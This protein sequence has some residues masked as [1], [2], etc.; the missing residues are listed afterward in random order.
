MSDA[1]P[2]VGLRN[3]SGLRT[4]FRVLGPVVVGVGL[5]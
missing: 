4:L 3:Q 2:P 1:T 5:G